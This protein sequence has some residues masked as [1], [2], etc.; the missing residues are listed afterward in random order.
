MTFARTPA[1]GPFSATGK[2]LSCGPVTKN[3]KA[4]GTFTV[5]EGTLDTGVV[6]DFG[7]KAPP[8]NIGDLVSLEVMKEY[9]KYAVKNLYASGSSAPPATPLA[10]RAPSAAGTTTPGA[11]APAYSGGKVFPLP[12]EHGDTAII[13]QNALTN[14]VKTVGDHAALPAGIETSDGAAWDALTDRILQTA[15]KYA[16]FSAGHLDAALLEQAAGGK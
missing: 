14:A 2:L 13:R 11:P 3:K 7:F 5:Y 8:F 4:G 16:A 12:R 10:P 1:T 15:Y 6:I 9:G